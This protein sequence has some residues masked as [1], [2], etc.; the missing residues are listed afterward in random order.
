MELLE[1]GLVRGDVFKGAELPDRR[2]D[3]VDV[4]EAQNL[5]QGRICVAD[6]AGLRFQ[7]EDAVLGRF[8]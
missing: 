4:G 8:K 2:V 5:G 3:Q 6:L 7:N 1:L